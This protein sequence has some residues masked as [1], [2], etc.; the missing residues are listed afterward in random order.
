[1]YVISSASL[2]FPSPAVDNVNYLDLIPERVTCIKQ[3]LI[4]CFQ[5]REEVQME[6]MASK[7]LQIIIKENVIIFFQDNRNALPLEME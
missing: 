6:I 4:C 3:E 2:N 1:M 7:M 5:Q